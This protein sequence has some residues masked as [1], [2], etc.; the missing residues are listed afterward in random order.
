METEFCNVIGVIFLGGI[1]VLLLRRLL[2]QARIGSPLA[3]NPSVGS[4]ANR[5][6]GRPDRR[7]G[8]G[9]ISIGDEGV[10]VS[11]VEF[12]LLADDVDLS[13]PRVDRLA[14]T[15]GLKLDSK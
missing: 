9:L 5:V 6:L 4:V 2:P 11:V 12:P 1:V 10:E 7:E 3:V 13:V 15:I 14:N 8:N